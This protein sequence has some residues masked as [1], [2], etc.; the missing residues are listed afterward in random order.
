MVL[1]ILDGWET[2]YSGGQGRQCVY[3]VMTGRQCV[4]LF[5]EFIDLSKKFC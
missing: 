5:T 2:E 1:G 4:P 3:V